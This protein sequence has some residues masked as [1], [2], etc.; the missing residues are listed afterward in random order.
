[1][2]TVD[3]ADKIAVLKNG[4]VA[5]SDTPA[6]LKDANGIYSHMLSVQMQTENLKMA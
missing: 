2:R 3:G 1:M 6:K 5:E 4:K